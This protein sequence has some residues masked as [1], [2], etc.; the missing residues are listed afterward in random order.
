[1]QR[2]ASLTQ[3]TQNYGHAPT[4]K[5]TNKQTNKHRSAG[6]ASSRPRFALPSLPGVLSRMLRRAEYETVAGE[7]DTAAVAGIRV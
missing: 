7:Q 5:Q 1:V 4:N 3:L 2:R 6:D